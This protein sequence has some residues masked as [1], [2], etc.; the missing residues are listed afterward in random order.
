MNT[1]VITRCY[2]NMFVDIS[3]LPVIDP[4]L[5][6]VFDDYNFTLV[7]HWPTTTLPVQRCSDADYI[8]DDLVLDCYRNLDYRMIDHVDYTNRIIRSMVYYSNWLVTSIS[9]TG[10]NAPLNLLIDDYGKKDI[11]PGKKRYIIANY[12]GLNSVPVMVQ[13]PKTQARLAGRPIYTV[14]QML[15]V[16]HHNVSIQLHKG[17][18][19]ECS[20]H[21][22]TNFRDQNG[23]DSW[24]HTAKTQADGK[25]SILA[26]IQQHGIHVNCPTAIASTTTY[27]G[28]YRVHVNHNATDH[29][30]YLDIADP[31]MLSYNLWE[32]YYHFDSGVG[33]KSCP[34]S[35]IRIINKLGDPLWTM[36]SDL[37]AT[38]QRLHI[39]DPKLPH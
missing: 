35:G 27:D 37:L 7:T 38:L 16:Y 31:T 34:Q 3:S 32:L 23:Y 2:F 19:L 10:V 4:N 17:Y 25:H 8:P 5:H 13:Q 30:F 24:H 14:D 12:M 26:Y 36:Q 18:K 22:A 11:H 1:G 6:K 33:E 39:P 21:G 9:E 29:D 20:W 28:V 15:A